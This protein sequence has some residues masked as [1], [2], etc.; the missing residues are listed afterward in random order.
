MSQNDFVSWALSPDRTQEEAYCAELLVDFG[1][2]HWRFKNNQPRPLSIPQEIEAKKRRKLNP[3]HRVKLKREDV[4]RAAA[5]LPLL[6]SLRLET[7][8]DRPLRDLSGLRFFTHFEEAHIM[9]TEVAD[10]SVLREFKPLKRLWLTDDAVEDLAPVGTLVGL[11][12]LRLRLRQPWPVLRALAALEKVQ[13][14]EYAGNLLALE[15][16]PRLAGVREVKMENHFTATLPLRDCQRLPE[17]PELDA[18]ELLGVYRLDGIARWPR[19]RTLMLGGP[20]RDLRPLTGLGAL[21]HLTL[22]TPETLDL[23]PLAKLPELRR[24][25]VVGDRPQDYSVLAE[26]PRLHE[27]SS[28]GCDINQMELATLHAVLTPWAEEFA[29]PEPRPLPP[30]RFVALPHDK[31]PRV[32]RAP[33]PTLWDGDHGMGESETRWVKRRVG[34]AIARRL[35]MERWGEMDHWVGTPGTTSMTVRSLEAAERLAEVVEAVR[36][37]LAATLHPWAVGFYIMLDNEW[38]RTE[39][40]ELSEALDEQREV[41]E[42]REFRARQKEHKEFLEREH[43]LRLRQ[44]EG[45]PV[46][47]EEF[48][49]PD[50]PPIEAVA[51]E[52]DAEAEDDGDVIVPLH[53]DEHPL[54][55]RL[56]VYGLITEAG[57]FVTD[58]SKDAAE[59]LMGRKVDAA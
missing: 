8:D 35:K 39:D 6:K 52:E 11:E 21:T 42:L 25:L 33:G 23:S 46:D 43:R 28:E 56:F 4:E 31:L 55:E 36:E 5:M 7:H 49:P 47:P 10:C 38:R 15:E 19:L 59:H 14:F 58:Q 9:W 12:E 48:A 44:Q 29:A 53:E 34:V 17:M 1:M 2:T 18:F 50:V 20:Y 57:L 40:E 3:A 22:K 45:H 16:L 32:Q 51:E 24:L 37:V 13:K 41:E 26:A 27:V 30:L 54:A